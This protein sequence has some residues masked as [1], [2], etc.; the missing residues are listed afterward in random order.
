VS[1]AAIVK[2]LGESGIYFDCLI[3]RS[4]RL[5]ILLVRDKPNRSPVKIDGVDS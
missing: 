4:Q 5:F 1:Q 3:E 2:G